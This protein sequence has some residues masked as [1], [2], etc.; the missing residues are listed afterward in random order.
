MIQFTE[1]KE[2]TRDAFEKDELFE[3]LIGKNNYKLQV[4]DA[5]VDV[6]TD[7]T[8]IIP[9]GIYS[10]YKETKDNTIIVKYE[11]AIRN[12]INGIYIDLWCA[13]NILYF[14][15]DNEMMG[16]SPF[17]INKNIING[18]K[19]K[20]IDSKEELKKLLPYG[21]GGWNMYEDILR[22]NQNFVKDWG[23]SFLR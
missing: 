22:L 14:Q 2:K 23:Y 19:N 11:D 5:E 20:I 1:I 15:F 18:L 12:A 8:R 13:V 16:K 3:F 10:L 7:W 6:P 4:I 9:N 21:K 17:Y